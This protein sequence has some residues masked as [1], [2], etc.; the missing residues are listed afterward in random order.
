MRKTFAV[1]L[2]MGALFIGA[3][4]AFADQPPGLLGDE[5]QPG[6]QGVP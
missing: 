3:P 2:S 5:G 1:L 6:N 4:P